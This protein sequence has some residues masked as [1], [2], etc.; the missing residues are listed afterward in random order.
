MGQLALPNLHCLTS[1]PYQPGEVDVIVP[2]FQ[3]WKLRLR[4]VQSLTKVTQPLIARGKDLCWFQSPVLFL[5]S[6]CTN[7]VEIEIGEPTLRYGCGLT[8]GNCILVTGN[9][10]WGSRD[11]AISSSLNLKRQPSQLLLWVSH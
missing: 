11:R 7:D 1:S 4:E 2:I 6:L 3:K 8:K 10:V 9:L 5:S